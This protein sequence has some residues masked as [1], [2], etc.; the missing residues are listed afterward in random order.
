MGARAG[1]R[2]T[3]PNS[4]LH[5]H[6]LDAPNHTQSHGRSSWSS[7]N[8]PQQPSAQP[9][10]RRAK[11]HPIPRALELELVERAP[12]A[13]RTART[14]STNSPTS[15]RTT[16]PTKSPHP[17]HQQPNEQPH[18]QHQQPNEKPAPSAPTAQ[19]TA[20]PSAPT[21][22][23][24]APSA[25][26]AQRAARTL[27]T[28]SPTNSPHPQHQQ[29]NEQPH[30]HLHPASSPHPQHHQPNEKPTPSATYP[31]PLARGSS[32]FIGA[33]LWRCSFSV[34]DSW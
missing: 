17:Q 18:P 30:Q 1:A 3:R 33:A 26:T 6:S 9:L 29:P 25:P 31:A 10:V 19:R 12:T 27:S 28:N 20:A 4:P 34:V 32:I 2:R 8:A 21:A 5:S 14:L 15:S 16:S 13:Q 7:S 22:Q 23:R 11:S 24:A